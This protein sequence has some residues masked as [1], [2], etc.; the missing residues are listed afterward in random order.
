MIKI[1]NRFLYINYSS[2]LIAILP[3]NYQGNLGGKMAEQ[4]AGVADFESAFFIHGGKNEAF[5]D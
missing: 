1:F 5:C 3:P 2:F 4:K